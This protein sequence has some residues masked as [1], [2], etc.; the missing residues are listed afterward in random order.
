MLT[1][2]KTHNKRKTSAAPSANKKEKLEHIIA[3]FAWII[4]KQDR[5][6]LNTRLT[7]MLIRIHKAYDLTVDILEKVSVEFNYIIINSSM[8]YIKIYITSVT[9]SVDGFYSVG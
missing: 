3:E 7:P 5:T 4:L 6:C 8:L 1:H 2:K 9:L